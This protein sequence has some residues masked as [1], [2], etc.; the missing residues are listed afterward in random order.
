M[1]NDTI[2]TLIALTKGAV[3]G[4]LILLLALGLSYPLR[5]CIGPGTPA[6]PRRVDTVLTIRYDTVYVHDTVYTPVYRPMPAARG[7]DTATGEAYAVYRDQYRDS[8]IDLTIT[9]TIGGDAILARQLRY[10]VLA[11]RVI[12]TVERNITRTVSARGGI[13]PAVAVYANTLPAYAVGGGVDYRGYRVLVL[14]GYQGKPFI[15]LQLGLT[16]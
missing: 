5:R 2:R 6:S 16:F 8:L 4:C 7:V 12:Q 10:R 1:N 9:D 3:I 11:P 15:G 14:A 13:R